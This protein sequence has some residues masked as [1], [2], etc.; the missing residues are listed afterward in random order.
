MP[1][2]PNTWTK[3]SDNGSNCVEVMLT[4]TGVLVRNS[5][6]PDSGS[7]AFTF[8]EWHAHTRGQ[9]LGVFDLPSGLV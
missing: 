3:F 5:N 4:E 1:L 2:R 8:A 9:K 7:I 6:R